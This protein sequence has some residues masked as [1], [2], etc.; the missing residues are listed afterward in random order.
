MNQV[1]R[2]IL[3]TKARLD[4]SLHS[5]RV[6][7][8]DFS[9]INEDIPKSLEILSNFGAL[10]LLFDQEKFVSTEFENVCIKKVKD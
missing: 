9:G 2:N 7:P 5:S 10:K 8:Y 4:Q 3:N 1:N 6:K